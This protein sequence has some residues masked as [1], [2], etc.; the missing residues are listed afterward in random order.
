MRKSTFVALLLILG[1]VTV[2]AGMASASQV[3]VLV[4]VVGTGY[5]T[6]VSIYDGI[7]PYSGGVYAERFDL[8]ITGVTGQS[9]RTIGYC[10]DLAH[11]SRDPFQ[12]WS[13]IPTGDYV[14]ASWLM[15]SYEPYY[16]GAMAGYTARETSNALQVAIWETIADLGPSGSWNLGSGLFRLTSAPANVYALAGVMLDSLVGAQNAGQ[17]TLANLK[18]SYTVLNGSRNTP[19]AQGMLAVSGTPEPGSLLL[20]GSAIGYLGL[21]RRRASRR[22]QGNRQR[23]A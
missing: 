11:Y 18:R 5:R 1:L 16:N 13:Q 12:A 2:P 22:R 8:K 3:P 9:Y 10:V 7:M 17:V 6:V 4:D 23:T 14:S 21:R 15:D 19:V 20:L